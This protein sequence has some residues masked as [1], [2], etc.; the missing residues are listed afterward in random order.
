MGFALAFKSFFCYTF[1]SMFFLGIEC[2]IHDEKINMD[3]K[4]LQ[5]CKNFNYGL[6]NDQIWTLF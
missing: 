5:N 2:M 6:L 1:I 4:K 3:C